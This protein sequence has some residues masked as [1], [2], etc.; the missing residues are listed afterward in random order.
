MAGFRTLVIYFVVI[1]LYFIPS[2]IAHRRK[3]TNRSYVYAINLFLG[4]SFIG[5]IIAFVMAVR[6]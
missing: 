4:W 5:W 1:C 2:L 6:T 3:A